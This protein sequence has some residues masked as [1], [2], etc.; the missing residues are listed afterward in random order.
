MSGGG[1]CGMYDITQCGHEGYGGW[2]AKCYSENNKG[3]YTWQWE[4]DNNNCYPMRCDSPAQ[5]SCVPKQHFVQDPDN[6]VIT[7]DA[8][9]YYEGSDCNHV[10]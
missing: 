9:S 2:C 1:Q 3:G 10:V 4:G 7:S 8:I 6:P 5:W